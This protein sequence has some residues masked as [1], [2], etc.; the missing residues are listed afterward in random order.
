M[1]TGAWQVHAHW[2]SPWAYLATGFVAGVF[3]GAPVTWLAVNIAFSNAVGRA[4][5]W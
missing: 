1:A 4:F 5:G 2:G 3:V